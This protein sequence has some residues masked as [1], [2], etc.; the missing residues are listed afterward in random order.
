MAE[1]I[2]TIDKDIQVRIDNFNKYVNRFYKIVP[3]FQEEGDTTKLDQEA[4]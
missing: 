1:A 2:D 3:D 4:G